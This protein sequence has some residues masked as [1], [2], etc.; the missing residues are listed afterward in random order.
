ML[1]DGDSNDLDLDVTWTVDETAADAEKT[2]A[3]ICSACNDLEDG[4]RL[5]NFGASLHRV[6]FLSL[7]RRVLDNMATFYSVASNGLIS[8][9]R[10]HLI[11]VIRI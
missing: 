11:G 4:V 5:C 8:P 9:T 6:S 1:F 10:G 3:S 7:E 2:V